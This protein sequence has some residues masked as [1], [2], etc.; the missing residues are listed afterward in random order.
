MCSSGPIRS[1]SRCTTTSRTPRLNALCANRELPDRVERA[2]RQA[3]LWTRCATAAR[4]GTALSGGQQQRCA[5]RAARN[6]PDVLLMDEPCSALT[7]RDA[8]HQELIVE[9]KR[10]YTI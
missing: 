6:E 2:L 7:D 3:A 10:T 5:S 1:P 8:A 4:A 9:L